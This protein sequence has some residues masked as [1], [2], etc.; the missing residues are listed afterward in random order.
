MFRKQCHHDNGDQPAQR[1]LK[2]SELHVHVKFGACTQW[3][4]HGFKVG[5]DHH[6]ERGS[7]SLYGAG[8]E[9]QWGP[10]A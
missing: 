9:P 6:G 5:G 4:N 10:G 8:A 3:R 7:A 2:L 1:P